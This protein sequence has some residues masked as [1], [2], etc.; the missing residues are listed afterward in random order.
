MPENGRLT[1][2]SS[3]PLGSHALE[4][5]VL[6]GAARVRALMLYPQE[7]QSVPTVLPHLIPGQFV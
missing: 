3:G 7:L 6:A 4:V 5:V 1:R 2:H